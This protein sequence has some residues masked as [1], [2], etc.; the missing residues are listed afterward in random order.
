MLLTYSELLSIDVRLFLAFAGAVMT[1][2]VLGI[3]FHEFSHAF[4][5]NMLGDPTA[6]LQGRVTLNPAAHLDPTGT[7]FLAARRFGWASRPP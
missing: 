1:A 2:L 4:T 7:A 5:A 3:A 6:K